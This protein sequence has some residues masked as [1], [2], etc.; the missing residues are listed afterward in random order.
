MISMPE[1][2]TDGSVELLGPVLDYGCS[3]W[4]SSSQQAAN[5][6]YSGVKLWGKD[7]LVDIEQ[8]LAQ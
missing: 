3:P 1:A 4:T 8:Q 2:T 5:L 7:D 6:Y